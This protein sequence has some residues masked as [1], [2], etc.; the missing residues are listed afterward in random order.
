MAGLNQEYELDRSQILGR[1]PFPTLMQAD[2]TV[3]S[4]ESRRNAKVYI[5]QQERTTMANVPQKENEKL[6]LEKIERRKCDHFMRIS[7]LRQVLDI[8]WTS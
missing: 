1:I 4:E 5:N 6:K 3:Q 2:A 7:M 8:T